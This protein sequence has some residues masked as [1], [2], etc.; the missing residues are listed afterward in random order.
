MGWC[1]SIT[2]FSPLFGGISHNEAEAQGLLLQHCIQV[3]GNSGRKHGNQQVKMIG[4][5]S[6]NGG[7]M[8]CRYRD[9]MT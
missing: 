5:D 6:I 3:G 8:Y 2:F 9:G 1:P 7:T 4:L